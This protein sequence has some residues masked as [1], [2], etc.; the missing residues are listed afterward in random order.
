MHDPSTL[1]W[2]IK[3]PWKTGKAPYRSRDSLIQVWHEDPELDGSDDSCGWFTPK[4]GKEQI[5]K[6]RKLAADHRKELWEEVGNGKFHP[7]FDPITMGH[8]VFEQIS[9]A[10][11]RKRLSFRELPQIMNLLTNAFD[12]FHDAFVRTQDVYDMERTYFF[13]A[14]SLGRIR[15]P[16]W[17]HPRFHFH[18]F[19]INVLPLMRIKR[20]L[21]TRCEQCGKRF[22]YGESPVSNQW[23]REKVGWFKGET[24]LF[25]MNCD[26]VNY[27]PM[28]DQG[29]QG[30]V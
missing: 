14:R 20:F 2:E 13:I 23:D 27:K 22:A 5:E 30:T 16:W 21:F 15:R 12:S 1:A 18:H 3:T 10:M 11:H 28:E 25:H 7:R 24:G 17:K 29:V 19:R 9:W 6:L 8:N 26:R 4:L